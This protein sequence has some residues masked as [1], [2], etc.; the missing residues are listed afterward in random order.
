MVQKKTE[1]S[2]HFHQNHI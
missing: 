1:C 2:Q